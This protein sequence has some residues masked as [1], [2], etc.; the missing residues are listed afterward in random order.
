MPAKVS[1]QLDKVCKS[2]KNQWLATQNSGLSIAEM[3]YEY[4]FLVGPSLK[5]NCK[6]SDPKI[7]CE[8]Y[9]VLTAIPLS[10][11]ESMSEERLKF[12]EQSWADLAAK[13]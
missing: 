2:A 10:K 11:V 3:V 6:S 7:D 12:Y 4:G 1:G 9:S 8:K 5:R 13:L